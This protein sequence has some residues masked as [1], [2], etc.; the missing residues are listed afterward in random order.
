MQDTGIAF[1]TCL[2]E[3]F[4]EKNAKGD[5]ITKVLEKERY[6]NLATLQPDSIGGPSVAKKMRIFSLG[7]YGY[8]WYRYNR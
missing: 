8:K 3:I 7:I 2:K 1:H 5:I 4:N 6:L